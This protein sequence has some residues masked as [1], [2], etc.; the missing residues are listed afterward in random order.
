MSEGYILFSEEQRFRQPWLIA[1]VA[2]VAAFAWYAFVLQ[3]LMGT[4]VGSNPAPD[5]VVVVI[6]LAFGISLPAL[7]LVLRLETQVTPHALCFRMYPIHLK[8]REYPF[9]GIRDAV[10]MKYRPLR[11]YGG[12][13]IRWGRRGIA[14]TVAGDE[15]VEITL[16][17]GRRFLLG[18]SNAEELAQVLQMHLQRRKA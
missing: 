3:F 17:D 13:G 9:A 1:L 2:I 8:W 5:A 15:G 10:R 18:S 6:L 11:D 4:P 7:F 12:W 14:Y 16:E